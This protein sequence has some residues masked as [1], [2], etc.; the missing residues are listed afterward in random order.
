MKT[1]EV[2]TVVYLPRAEVFAFLRDFPRYA[3]YSKYLEG[4]EQTGDGGPGTAYRLQF[5]WWVL[6]YTAHTR[7][8]SVDPPDR[9][10]WTVTRDLHA[11]G[12]WELEATTP[13]PDR[14]AATR[15]RFVVDYDPGA[16][17]SHLVDLPRL[18][19]F[20]RVVDRVQDL[21][22]EEGERVVER[23]VRDLEGESREVDLR[24]ETR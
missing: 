6:S 23:I 18:V 4:V 20:D 17:G 5:R 24:V 9:L 15:V 3:D 13:P 14:E 19:S 10:D 22:V 7:V 21:I 8:T 2:S 12:R 16:V 1:A 11:S